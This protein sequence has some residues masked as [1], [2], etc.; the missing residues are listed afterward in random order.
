MARPDVDA[1]LPLSTLPTDRVI[2]VQ[3][4]TVAQMAVALDP[5]PAAAPV[6]ISCELGDVS[7]AP[8]AVRDH[9]LERLEAVARAQVQ[10]WLPAA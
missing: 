7:A 2:R 10:T 1:L 6:V 5:L 3:G 9:L 8:T 4:P